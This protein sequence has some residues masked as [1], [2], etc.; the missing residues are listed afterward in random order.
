MNPRSLPP[1][2]R[3]L[4]V[5][6]DVLIAMLLVLV[7]VRAI[8]GAAENAAAVV[9]AAGA[10]GVVYLTRAFVLSS[11][12][13]ET[14]GAVWIGLLSLA[15]LIVVFL[16]PNGVWLAFP[17]F[18]LDLHLLP[19][20]WGLAAVATTTGAAIGG[21]AWHQDTFTVGMVIGPVIGAGVAVATVL[22]YQALH[23][24][25]E[26]RRDLIEEL[27]AT[28]AE[29]A[30]AER[31]AGTLLER[32][33]LAREIHDTLAQG[34]SSIQLLLRATERAIPV[35]PA[36]AAG[37]VEQAREAA[38]DNLAEARRFVHALS[39]PD[40]QHDGLRAAL[41]RLCARRPTGAPDLSVRFR[42]KG[43]PA[44]LPTPYEVALLRVAQA[45]LANTAQHARA[46]HAEITLSYLG[47][48]VALDVVDDGDGFAPVDDTGTADH[49]G[50]GLRGMRSRAQELGG[51]FT[52]E[53]A[54]G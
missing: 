19:P 11:T 26:Q 37:Y 36:V 41:E 5:C 18:F 21:F 13:P 9:V 32:E 34:L 4:R 2:L 31:K 6:V 50:F 52:V 16:T 44:E 25:S 51:D 22:G 14:A 54:P 3:L 47:T 40:L 7:V 48:A 30:A 33:R 24:E 8:S 12:R 49:E 17:L 53:S 15:W 35:E 42:V 27:L 23:R 38:Q 20:R 28:R 43:E 29:L 10:M 1:V 46:R 39:P 45:A